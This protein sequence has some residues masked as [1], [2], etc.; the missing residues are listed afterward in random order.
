MRLADV[1]T[2]SDSNAS[3][4]LLECYILHSSI[5]AEDSFAASWSKFFEVVAAGCVKTKDD[6]KVRSLT[7]SLSDCCLTALSSIS[8]S[9][10]MSESILSGQGMSENS[11]T[12]PVGDLSSLLLYSLSL[13][14]AVD[15]DENGQDD[16]DNLLG[17][18]GRLYE[19]ANRLFAM[20]QLG[21]GLSSNQVRRVCEEN[22]YN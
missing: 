20:T 8:E 13:S 4:K 6:A 18:F 12:V 1:L 19:S 21:S 11:N 7:N 22:N 2:K 10:M 3:R 15:T 5:H 9:K 16:C 17:M 14:N